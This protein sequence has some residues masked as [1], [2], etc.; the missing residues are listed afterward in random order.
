M[1]QQRS[2]EKE[3]KTNKI[4]IGLVGRKK[5]DIERERKKIHTYIPLVNL[6]K[7]WCG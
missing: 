7:L 4:K 5:D 3:I 6:K 2:F 1:Q